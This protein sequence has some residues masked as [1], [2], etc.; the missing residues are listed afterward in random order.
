MKGKKLT[1]AILSALMCASLIGGTASAATPHTSAEKGTVEMTNKV[2]I[3]YKTADEIA[4]ENN[5]NDNPFGLVYRGAITK[6]EAGKVNIHPISYM[7]RGLKIAANVYT[8]AGWKESD[9]NKYAAIV[10]AHP[11]GGVKEQVA[12]LFAQRMAEKGYITIAADAA[13]QGASEGEPRNLDIPSSRVE[14]IHRMADVIALFPGVNPDRLAALGICGGGGYTAKAAQTDKRFKAVA[15]LSMFNSGMVRRN[16]FLNQ[17]AQM[18]VIQKRLEDASKARAEEAAGR[19]A[20]YTP[21]MIDM[22]RA[23]AEKLP[24]AFTATAGSTTASRT[25]IRNPRSATRSR[26]SWIS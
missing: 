21:D 25:V 26:A 20:R 23:E 9:K 16:G 2:D 8:P 6:N 15:T 13:Y 7:S 18:D 5:Y 11:N 17:Q 12:G 1:V 22:P 4:A 10:V 24:Y 19:E 3:H 14:D